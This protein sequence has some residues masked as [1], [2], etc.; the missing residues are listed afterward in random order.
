MISLSGPGFE[1]LRL[2]SHPPKPLRGVGGFS[3]RLRDAALQAGPSLKMYPLIRDSAV[4][5]SAPSA[6]TAYP[7]LP[8]YDQRIAPALVPISSMTATP[9]RANCRAA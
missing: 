6:G 4:P 2:H 5:E 3:F 9:P 7:R 8:L 1:S